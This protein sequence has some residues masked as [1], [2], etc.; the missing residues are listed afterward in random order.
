MQIPKTLLP[1]PLL[2]LLRPLPLLRRHHHHTRRPLRAARRAQLRTTRDENVG[3]AVVLAQHGDVRDDVHWRDVGGEDDDAV[4]C[5]GGFLAGGGGGRFADCFDA[6][7][8][9]ALEGFGFGGWDV[10]D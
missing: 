2:L 10:Y 7:F 3:D 9:A 5:V 4:G 8:Y 6:F 1:L